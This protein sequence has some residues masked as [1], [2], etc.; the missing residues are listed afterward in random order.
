V[1]REPS[2]YFVCHNGTDRDVQPDLM[3]I[4]WRGGMFATDGTFV[5]QKGYA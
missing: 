5:G 2:K 4:D 3:W 1:C